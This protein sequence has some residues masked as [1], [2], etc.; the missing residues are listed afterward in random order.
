MQVTVEVPESFYSLPL[1][2]QEYI[3]RRA[4]EKQR[5]TRQN[6]LEAL[7][8]APDAET[9]MTEEEQLAMIDKVRQEIYEEKYGK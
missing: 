8:Q 5:T 3:I 7:R 2:E 1:R 9:G 6:F 4:L